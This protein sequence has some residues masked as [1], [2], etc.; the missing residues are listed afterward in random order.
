MVVKPPGVL[1]P[2]SAT[3]MCL[4]DGEGNLANSSGMAFSSGNVANGAAVATIP[5]VASKFSFISGFS[6]F[7]AGATAASIVLVTIT[8]LI[9]GVT[10]TYP[11]A[12]VAGALLQNVPIHVQYKMPIQSSAIN[13]PIVVTCPALGAGNTNNSVNVQG[14][15]L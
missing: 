8:G 11:L 14:H 3:Y 2:D 6:V 9:G 7:G 10:L 13:T 15:Y 4:L 12:V 1:S 5:A